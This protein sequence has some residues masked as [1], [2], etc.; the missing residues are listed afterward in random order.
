MECD[1]TCRVNK[2]VWMPPGRPSPCGDVAFLKD[3][4]KRLDPCDVSVILRTRAFIR[5]A[6][7]DVQE[8]GFEK[9]PRR[10]AESARLDHSHGTLN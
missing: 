4:I 3:E 10:F 1:G 2:V 6:C 7:C 8:A 9:V 5:H